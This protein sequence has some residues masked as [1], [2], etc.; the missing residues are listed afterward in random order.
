[1]DKLAFAYAG[2]GIYWNDIIVAAAAGFTLLL[3]LALCTSARTGFFRTIGCVLLSVVLALALSR[4][5]HWYCRFSQYE[6]LKAAM[7][8]LDGEFALV[9]AVI[10][11]AIAA[12][13]TGG[14]RMLDCAAVAGMLGISLGR[15]SALFGSANK[16]WIIF[17]AGTGMPLASTVTN[18][19]TGAVEPRFATFMFQS[20]VALVF[21][22]I[23][24]LMFFSR[25]PRR[26]G[27]VAIFFA[28]LFSACEIVLDS[29]RYDALHLRSNGFVSLE[30][31]IGLVC[32]VLIVAL[33]SRRAIICR[34]LTVA[35]WLI[36][37]IFLACAGGAGY[38]EYYVQRHGDSYAMSYGL[39]SLAL[40]AIV[41]DITVLYSL[42]RPRYE[43]N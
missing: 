32:L 4:F 39:M 41:A 37:L 43:H 30:Q 21:G 12:A 2:G 16:G 36:W 27:D 24:L 31:I 19:A 40:L 1:M 42:S 29:T 9:G 7:T 33:L 3:F 26:D 28:V 22:V 17:P 10:G 6:S 25:R 35:N 5:I 20:G 38:M 18:A 34:G 15:L 11:C 13:I 14:G 8:R 23:L